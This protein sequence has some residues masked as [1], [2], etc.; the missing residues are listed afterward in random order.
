MTFRIWFHPPTGYVAAVRGE[1]YLGKPR[2]QRWICG[3]HCRIGIWTDNDNGTKKKKTILAYL[4]VTEKKK[5]LDGC[6]TFE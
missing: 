2:Q 4:K 5:F 1:A 6:I 3:G